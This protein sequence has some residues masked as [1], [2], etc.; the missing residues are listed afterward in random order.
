MKVGYARVSTAGQARYGASLEEQEKLLEA[1][2]DK[3]YEETYTGK[4]TV[5]PVLQS[6]LNSLK[7]GDSLLVTKLDRIAR[8]A[9]EGLELVD[10]LS[11]CRCLCTS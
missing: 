3:I 4:T 5:R 1:G 10:K 8:S 6:L 7:S 9:R 11:G 2:A